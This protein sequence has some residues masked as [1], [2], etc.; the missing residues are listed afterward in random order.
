M[1]TIS[2]NEILAL[3]AAGQPVL[4]IDVRESYRQA[5]LDAGGLKIPF[6]QIARHAELLRPYKD[7]LTV[8]CCLRPSGSQR[9]QVAFVTLQ[10][11]GF[12]DVLELENG[13]YQGWI[14]KLGRNFKLPVGAQTL[15]V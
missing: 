15:G 4:C 11:L 6:N 13:L 5:T 10:K 7:C 12:S 2:W 1:K 8:V 9:T 3:T 14:L